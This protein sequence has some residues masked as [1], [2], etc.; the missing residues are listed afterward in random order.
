[1]E[2]IQREVFCRIGRDMRTGKLFIENLGI[3]DLDKK[4]TDLV[5]KRLKMDSKKLYKKTRKIIKFNTLSIAG[6]DYLAEKVVRL[7]FVITISVEECELI[8]DM[9]KK[10]KEKRDREEIRRALENTTFVEKK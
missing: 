4:I 2:I 10:E 8:D 1:M 9:S 5:C 6:D 7:K 3:D